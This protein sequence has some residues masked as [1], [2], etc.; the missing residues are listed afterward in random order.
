MRFLNA[1][2]SRVG[3]LADDPNQ[4][5]YV[6]YTYAGL[7][8][9]IKRHSPK[10][11]TYNGNGTILN[12]DGGTADEYNGYDVFGRA[13]AQLTSVGTGASP[14]TADRIDYRYNEDSSPKFAEP[15][16]SVMKPRSDFYTY[17]GLNRLSTVE[18]SLLN[19]GR[20]DTLGEW[21][22]PAETV[23]TMDILGNFTAIDHKHSGT[24]ASETRTHNAVNELTSRTITAQAPSY[25]IDDNFTDNDSVGWAVGDVATGGDGS[26]SATG[27]L[28]QC[29]TVVSV[30]GAPDSGTGSVMLVD[31][32]Y[33]DIVL[34]ATVVLDADAD[35]GGLVFGYRDKDNYWVLLASEISRNFKLYNV[36]S[37][38]WFLEASGGSVSA[39]GGTFNLRLEMRS[40]SVTGIYNGS[41][42]IIA[43]TDTTATVFAGQVGVWA[44]TGSAHVTVDNFKCRNAAAFCMVDGRFE[45]EL[46]N[47]RVSGGKLEF[48]NSDGTTRRSVLRHVRMGKAI[49]QADLTFRNGVDAGIILHYQD[50]ENF[51]VALLDDNGSGT[52][53][54]RLV[55]YINGDKQASLAAGSTFNLTDTSTYTVKAVINDDPATPRCRS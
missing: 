11:A 23:Y 45:D 39:T 3:Q 40:G 4:G 7:S 22:N 51:M 2:F 20:T 13:I 34:E 52:V 21:A 37:G 38:G 17:D 42:N 44:G 43:D 6:E 24:S 50:P 16:V 46:G 26:W 14:P 9:L 10:G 27:G 25:W 5:A 48:Y 53:T 41:T 15:Q 54:P 8:H 35:N 55:R 47:V 19:S 28:L 18:S 30:S 32:Y 29:D 33:Q 36:T 12:Y 49:T 1:P 31:G